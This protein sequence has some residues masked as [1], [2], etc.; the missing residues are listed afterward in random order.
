MADKPLL[1]IV[2]ED[3]LILNALSDFFD[4]EFAVVCAQQMNDV[5][6]VLSQYKE[7]TIDYALVDLGLPPN[8]HQPTE[9][10]AVISTLQSQRPE[11]AIVVVSGQAVRRHGQRARALGAADYAEKPC[12]PEVLLQKLRRAKETMVSNQEMMGLVGESPMMLRLREQIRVV[13][14]VAFPVLITGESGAGKEVVARALHATN[15]ADRTFL[16]VNCASIPDHLVEPTLFGHARGA[17]TGAHAAGAGYFGDVADGTLFLDEIDDLPEAVQPKLLRVLETGE[18]R[19]VGETQTRQC[20]ARIIAASKR[21][22]NS[23]G[24]SGNAGETARR[25]RIRDDLYYRLS[26]F[27]IAVPPLRALGDDRFL[28]LSHYRDIIVNDLGSA[29][30]ELSDEARALWAGYAFPGNVRELKNIVARLQVKHPGQTLAAA[31]V[32]EEMEQVQTAAQ[33]SDGANIADLPQQLVELSFLSD[34]M[35]KD[36]KM[37]PILTTLSQHY[38]VQLA[39]QHDGDVAATLRALAALGLSEEQLLRLAKYIKH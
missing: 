28:L 19:R 9:G 14:K 29:P 27:S 38:L 35:M 30:F 34:A 21:N 17:F 15:R 20:A 10:F 11:C 4:D 24:H 1:L 26:V 33:T 22:N 6:S 2:D 31:Q 16:A 23:G 7:R 12:A 25:S 36:K 32:S 3:E 37:L 5:K 18:Y 39:G 13:G 8:P